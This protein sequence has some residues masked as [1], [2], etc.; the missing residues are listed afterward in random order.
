[1]TEK[2][3]DMLAVGGKSNAL[4]RA[5]EVIELVLR[6]RSRLDELYSCLFCEDAWI[7]MRAIDV[8]EKVCRVRP[9]WLLP[10]IDRFPKELA[11]SSQPS[12][13]WHLAQIYGHVDLSDEHNRFAI[14]WLKN[15]LS[16]TDTDWIVA[17]NAMD[18]LMKFTKDGK[19]SNS[20]M[21]KLLIVQQHHKSKAVIKRSAKHLTEFNSS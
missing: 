19:F 21:I 20:E 16:S 18:T 1:M 5:N 15:L 3:L 14:N 8:L 17:A 6:D 7:R 2:F 9:D 4:G 11:G 13:Q 10:Y 12:I